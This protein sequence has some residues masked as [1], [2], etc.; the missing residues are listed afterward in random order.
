LT[1]QRI[2][3]HVSWHQIKIGHH[4][5]ASHQQKGRRICLNPAASRQGRIASIPWPGSLLKNAI[6]AF[7]QPS[8]S[9]KHGSQN[10]DFIVIFDIAS[11]R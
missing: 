9:A 2:R 7:F 1:A 4:F 11:M 10:A 5:S 8:P 6:V 3:G